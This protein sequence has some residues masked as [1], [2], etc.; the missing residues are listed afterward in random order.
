MTVRWENCVFVFLIA[1]AEVN[2]F[3]IIWCFVPPQM[4]ANKQ[5][6]S[7]VP[8]QAWMA[9]CEEQVGRPAP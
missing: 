9:M 6:L 3:L 5:L 4:A 7:L 1:L 2:A 8:P